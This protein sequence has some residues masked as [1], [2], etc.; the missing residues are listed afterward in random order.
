MA[1]EIEHFWTAV[2]RGWDIEPRAYF[3]KEAV[4]MGFA[5]AVEMAV[6]WMWK[7]HAKV[8][9]NEELKRGAEAAAVA[10]VPSG[11]WPLRCVQRAFV[12]GA[13]WWQF[14]RTGS[15]MFS[16]EREEAE[17]E[18]VKRYGEPTPEVIR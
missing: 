9:P 2:E 8:W 11:S 10:P 13:A 18:A 15:T 12:D 4:P 5:S 7:R 16:T 1:N 3:E 6:H 14:H 17:D